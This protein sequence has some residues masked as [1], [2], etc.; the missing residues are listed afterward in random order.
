MT[1]PATP[2]FNGLIL[3][4]GGARAA[5]QVGV[6]Q[7]LAET[8]PPSVKMPF[9]VISGVSAGA[10]NAAKLATHGEDFR[11]G[12]A[13]LADLWG[14]LK[15]DRIYRTDLRTVLGDS[16]RWV[17]GL[18]RG[19]DRAG[20]RSILNNQPLRE[21]LE[22]E[23]DFDAVQ[24]AIEAGSLRGLAVTAAGFTSAESV[25]YFQASADCAGWRRTRREGKPARLSA[26]H[27]MASVALPILFPAARIDGEWHG[28]GSLRQT[29]PISPAIHMGADR[30][31]I[32]AVRNEDPNLKRSD[33]PQP[34]PSFGQIGGYMLDS[35]FMDGI[36]TDL[37]RIQRINRTVAQ[38]G[39]NHASELRLVDARVVVPSA[40]I[41]EIVEAHKDAFP[42][43][44]RTL[45]G[46]IG[47][48]GP[49]GG[50]LLSYLLFDQGYCRALMDLGYKDGM[51]RKDELVPWLT[52]G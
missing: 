21:L 48:R 51:A 45:F 26:E 43:T 17:S 32:I 50:Q 46:L 27:V 16:L 47:A 11:E 36:Y 44:V 1:D 24:R 40:D 34:Y 18:G 42:R 12:V 20:V 2:R 28:D 22:D 31:L 6:L 10:I 38:V 30:I 41:R 15:V 49:A 3:P 14:N 9:P 33:L 39:G 7:A 19:L 25:T 4:G 52:G 35:L 8:L 13:R 5:Y 29:S 37:E 23:L